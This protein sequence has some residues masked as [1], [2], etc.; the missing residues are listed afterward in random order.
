VWTSDL[1]RRAATTIVVRLRREAQIRWL[2]ADYLT[3]QMST[4]TGQ[5]RAASRGALESSAG[6]QR[7][8]SHF[9]PHLG[10]AMPRAEFRAELAVAAGFLAAAVW[11]AVFAAP[12]GRS[13]S[14]SVALLF[15]LLYAG[16]SR[17]E[18]D[19]GSGYGP[20]TQLVLV[21]MLY[22]VPAGWTPLLVAAGLI[23]GKLPSF[24]AG[25]RH[26]DR[27]VAA[28]GDAWHAVGPAL[29]FVLA[30]VH[31]PRWS[32]WPILLAALAAQFMGD[33]AATAVREWL[34]LREVPKLSVRLLGAVYLADLCLSPIG[35]AVAFAAAG[36]QAAALLTLP[37]SG[38]LMFFARDRR[39]RMR[40]AVELSH[41]YR[42][43]ALLLGDVVEADDAYTGSHSRA[44]VDLVMAVGPKLG[45]DEEQMRRLEFA[46]LLHDIGKITIPN[47]IINKRGPLTDDEWTIMKTHTVEGEAMLLG[48]GGLLGEVGRIVRSCH[49]RYDGLGYPDRLA[50]EAIPVEARV[51]CC[52]DAFNAMV[53][54]RPYRGAMPLSEALNE[55]R[56]HRGKQFDPAVVD[57]L[58]GL[59]AAVPAPAVAVPTA[60]LAA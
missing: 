17:V 60:E 42:G 12:H 5:T 57:I 29:V 47:A 33:L 20:P 49:E 30:A 48:V 54:D 6:V 50:G 34:R 7:L 51:I 55:L 32:D 3:N 15:V 36:H 59:H 2:R 39:A 43:T 52:C 41:A 31:S 10:E 9:R 35:L 14:W 25:T 1:S 28:I 37:L 23:V 56:V 19:V 22:A 13:G 18:F 46:A 21:P 24:L 45:L 11:L 58:L 16:T 26:P 40:T 4:G 53:T 44:V 8:L 38:L 27:S